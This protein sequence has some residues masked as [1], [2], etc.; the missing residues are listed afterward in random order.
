MTERKRN[1]G[2]EERKKESEN[3]RTI[4]RKKEQPQKT[5]KRRKKAGVCCLSLVSSSAFS[6]AGVVR[7]V[8]VRLSACFPV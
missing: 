3:K 5:G 6:S 2:K 1:W 7:C 4:E 8:A